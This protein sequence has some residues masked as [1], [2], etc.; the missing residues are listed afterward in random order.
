[1]P[2][3]F[4]SL[5]QGASRL[6]RSGR[7]G[8]LAIGCSSLIVLLCACSIVASL[9]PSGRTPPAVPPSLP[10]TNTRVA[11]WTPT[12][13]PSAT[14]L[15]PADTHIP[16]RTPVLPTATLT[17]TRTPIP[18][19]ATATYTKTSVPPTPTRMPFTVTVPPPQPTPTAPAEPRV[20]IAMISFSGDDEYVTVTNRGMAAQDLSG[21]SI[22]SYSG[23][24]C[25]PVPEQVFTFPSGYILAAGASVRVHSGPA[26]AE[27][28]PSDLLWTRGAIWHNDGDRGDLHAPDGQ[29]VSSYA[30]GQCG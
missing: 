23:N 7:A 6:W 8:K 15:P 11:A 24:T 29:V 13:L 5:T 3:I 9:F 30:Y 22:Q 12:S 4:R 27:N 1:M 2:R 14:P 10:P 25:Q 26:A 21:W 28:P 20:V 18:P 17:Q 16:T 19:T